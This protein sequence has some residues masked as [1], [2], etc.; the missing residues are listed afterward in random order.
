MIQSHGLIQLNFQSHLQQT[1]LT[2]L[3]AGVEY[4]VRVRV[5]ALSDIGCSPVRR[6]EFAGGETERRIDP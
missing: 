5:R 4:I 3:D 6:V 1:I 2:G